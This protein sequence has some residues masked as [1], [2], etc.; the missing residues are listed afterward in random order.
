MAKIIRSNLGDFLIV[1]LIFLVM[2]G[3]IFSG[4][5]LIWKKPAFP[6]KIQEA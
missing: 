1:C 4:W 5:P 2:T 6:P 3:W